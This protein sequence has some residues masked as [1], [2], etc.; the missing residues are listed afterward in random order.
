[1]LGIFIIH[2]FLNFNF[3]I[4]NSKIYFIFS[5]S[6]TWF[7]A[8]LQYVQPCREEKYCVGFWVDFQEIICTLN[9]NIKY[10]YLP[11][12]FYFHNLR[13]F[14]SI[15]IAM[16]FT[17]FNKIIII[18]HLLKLA[19]FNEKIVNSMLFCGPGL[20]SRVRYT[21]LK[22]IRVLLHQSS[23]HSALADTRGSDKD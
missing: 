6:S 7:E 9:S 12:I 8:L 15:H 1:M 19:L 10:W 13:F 16:Y 17:P 5:F 4:F 11:L 23:Y 14:S 18:Y 20:P 3:S 22:L 2:P 21:K